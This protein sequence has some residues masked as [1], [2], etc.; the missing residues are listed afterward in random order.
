MT[1]TFICFICLIYSQFVGF[2]NAAYW[3]LIFSAVSGAFWR[4][5]TGVDESPPCFRLFVSLT[6]SHWTR[7]DRESLNTAWQGVI[8]RSAWFWRAVVETWKLWVSC[9][10]RQLLLLHWASGAALILHTLPNRGPLS[11]AEPSRAEPRPARRVAILGNVFNPSKKDVC[12]FFP[13]RPKL[14]LTDWFFVRVTNWVSDSPPHW[15]TDSLTDS[16]TLWLIHWH[17]RTPGCCCAC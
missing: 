1:D 17:T 15:L 12:V 16:Q 6:G 11:R 8:E 5:L 9:Q 13:K 3:L 2:L 10:N 4:W 14:Q 7:R